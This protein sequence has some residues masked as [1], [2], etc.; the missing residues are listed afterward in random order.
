MTYDE[1]MAIQTHT[2]LP[3]MLA[4]GR[5]GL[6][7]HW[8]KAEILVDAYRGNEGE[9][10]RIPFCRIMNMG[11]GALIERDNDPAA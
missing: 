7:N 5:M 4:D 1:F 11:G 10:I 3:I 2:P 9:Q 8:T 6:C